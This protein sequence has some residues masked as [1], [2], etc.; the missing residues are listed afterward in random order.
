MTEVN[1]LSRYKIE[2][3]FRAAGEDFF[4]QNNVIS[5]LDTGY[6]SP[7]MFSIYKRINKMSCHTGGCRPNLLTLHVDDCTPQNVQ[8]HAD[9]YGGC[10]NDYAIFTE[11]QADRVIRFY[12]SKANNRL[13]WLVHCWAGV[14]R[15]G[16]VGLFI[17]RLQGESDKDFYD[18]NTKVLPNPHILRTLESR[19]KAMSSS[20]CS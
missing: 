17:A 18:R 13:P 10:V 5:L 19:W 8:E 15:S 6:T 1:C 20:S 12:Q 2:E 14:S 11:G 16:A 7:F 9:I 4:D 3:L